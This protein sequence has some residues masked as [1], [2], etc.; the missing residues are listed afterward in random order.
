MSL[1]CL[2]AGTAFRGRKRWQRLSPVGG[3]VPVATARQEK[4]C[5]E[6][7]PIPTNERS[8]GMRTHY[9]ALGMTALMLAG[10]VVVVEANNTEQFQCKGGGTFTDGVETHIDTNGDRVSATL[11][12]GA[13]V[14]NTGR[15]IFQEE[16]EWIRRSAVT[17]Y[18]PAGTTDE[19]HINDRNKV[20]QQRAVFTDL[21]TGD[22]VFS[23]TKWAVQCFN[24]ATGKFTGRGEGLITGGTGENAG[25]TGTYKS[26]FSG[27]YLQ[28]GF[29]DGVFGGFGQFTFTSTGTLVRKAQ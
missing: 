4:D 29:K 20:G 16:A 26:R 11:D 21:E 22:Q 10:A 2:K 3:Q 23:Q 18:C 1:A 27:S 5:I 17:S 12:Q 25:A 13:E 14:C 28:F 19:L 8:S 24:A 9:L 15:A 6:D 7:S